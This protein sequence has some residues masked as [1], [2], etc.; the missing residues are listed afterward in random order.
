[1]KVFKFELDN[2][3]SAFAMFLDN[4]LQPICQY[5]DNMILTFTLLKFKIHIFIE[6]YII[7][8]LYYLLYVLAL[9]VI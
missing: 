6:Y 4:Q 9:C 5:T 3:L 8:Y 1:M 2:G 7:L